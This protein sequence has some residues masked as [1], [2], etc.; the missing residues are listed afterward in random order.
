VNLDLCL[1]FVLYE[2]L[3]FF[4]LFLF[5][6]VRVFGFLLN[7]NKSGKPVRELFTLQNELCAKENKKTKQN[8]K[9][10]SEFEILRSNQEKEKIRECENQANGP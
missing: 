2:N 1:L 8:D 5:F 10:M 3:E 7:K 4:V 6:L 9:K